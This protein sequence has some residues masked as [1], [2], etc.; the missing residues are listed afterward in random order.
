MDREKLEENVRDA[1]RDRRLKSNE[2]FQSWRAEWAQKAEAH[3]DRLAAQNLSYCDT[4]IAR[5]IIRQIR[6][7]FT[8]LD[9]QAAKVES[10]QQTLKEAYGG[11][12]REDE[13]S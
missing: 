2:D 7:M 3:K 12:E 4:Y 10:I 9:S 6:L 13:P 5:G 8:Q 1:E 11:T